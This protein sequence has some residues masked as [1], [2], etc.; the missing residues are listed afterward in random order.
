MIRMNHERVNALQCLSNFESLAIVSKN[1][2]AH[3]RI[4]LKL[5]WNGMKISERTDNNPTPTSPH[6]P[7]PIPDPIQ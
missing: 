4:I 1:V 2:N 6:F 5:E 3:A 7:F